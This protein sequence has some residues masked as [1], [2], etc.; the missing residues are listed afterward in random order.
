MIDWWLIPKQ[1]WKFPRRQSTSQKEEKLSLMQ[2]K[3]ASEETCGENIPTIP[4]CFQC[5][6]QQ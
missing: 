3:A 5:Y 1:D 2:D 4:V 6:S